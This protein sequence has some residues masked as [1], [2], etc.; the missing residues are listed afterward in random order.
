VAEAGGPLVLGTNAGAHAGARAPAAADAAPL[1]AGDVHAADDRLLALFEEALAAPEPEAAALGAPAPYADADAL[2]AVGEYDRAVAAVSRALARGCDRAGGLLRTALAF[3]RQGFFGEAVDAY[4]QAAAAGGALAARVGEARMLAELG[5]FL[6]A[7]RA[8]AAALDEHGAAVSAH[9]VLAHAVL[10]RAAATLGDD[11]AALHAAEH[12]TA[13]AARGALGDAVPGAPAVWPEVAAAWRALGEP[14]READAWARAVDADSTDARAR[15]ARAEA[16]ARAGGADEARALLEA[17]VGDRPGLADAARALARLRAAGG[18]AAGA[19]RLLA[20]VGLRDPWHVDALAELALA[21]ADAGRPADAAR[22]VE[23]ALRLDPDH[24]LA[25]A[26]AALVDEAGGVA[27]LA[28]AHARRAVE[29]EP[30]GEAARRARAVAARLGE[31][32]E[33]GAREGA[34]PA[35]PAAPTAAA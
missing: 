5:R 15:L 30:A 24:A 25:H 29:L 13:L 3:E 27:W 32:L 23:R 12:A 19:I 7:R 21:L 4:A 14:A 22:A 31:P 6:G 35:A 17:L 33:I 26:A 34:A 20:R 28:L 9:A 10:A 18:D 2:L 1:T 16:L 8:A 11:A